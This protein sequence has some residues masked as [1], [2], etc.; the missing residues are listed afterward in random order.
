MYKIGFQRFSKSFGC[1]IVQIS[2]F[3]FVPYTLKE[4]TEQIVGISDTMSEIQTFKF[5][6]SDSWDQTKILFGLVPAV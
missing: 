4:K 5:G 3:R 1:Q 6:L 2:D